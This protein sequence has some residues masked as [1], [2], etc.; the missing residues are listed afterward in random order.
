MLNV[1]RVQKLSNPASVASRYHLESERNFSEDYTVSSEVLGHGL[2]GSVV[3]AHGRKDNR[4]YALKTL[5][6]DSGKSKDSK[7]LQILTEV[8]IHLGMDHPNIAQ[9]KDVYESE[10]TIS[11]LTECCEGGELYAS[12]QEKGVYSND[13]AAEA[14]RQMLGVVNHLHARSIVHRDLKLE[15]FLYQG[16]D[17]HAQMDKYLKEMQSS[18]GNPTETEAPQ[19]KLIDFGFVRVWDPSKLMMTACGSAEYVSPDVLCGDGYTDKTDLWSIGVIVWMLLS[20]YPPFHGAKKEMISKIKSGRADWSHQS[21]WK[22]VSKDAQDFVRKLLDRDVDQRMDAAAALRHPW[23]SAA[24]P[25]MDSALVVDR[26]FCS[27]QQYVAGSKLRRAA[28][29]LLV[30]QLDCEETRELRAAFVSLDRNSK[31]WLSLEDFHRVMQD[32]E[33]S[34]NESH[35]N[36]FDRPEDLFAALDTNGDRRI[37]Y[38]DFVA[39]TTRVC[40][41]EHK[42]ALKATFARMDADSSGSI[43]TSDLKAALGKTFEGADVAELLS[44]Q[45]HCSELHFEDFVE[46]ITLSPFEVDVISPTKSTGNAFNLLA[47]FTAIV[48]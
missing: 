18:N 40:C 11:M 23:L 39:A 19:L 32:M 33:Q 6:K 12:L 29:L 45:P 36:D 8:E 48:A 35:F 14:T 13:E 42:R 17:P 27:M 26:T 38:S 3:V 30:Q 25:R 24:G 16:K 47:S 37:Y 5:R 15:N 41:K 44:G 22:N 9:V 28:L 46:A 31:G 21:R 1:A 10:S 43:G 7:L 20:G 34:S 4:R 2:C